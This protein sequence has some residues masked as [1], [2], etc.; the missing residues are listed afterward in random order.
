MSPLK[1][2]RY[3]LAT[4][5]LAGGILLCLPAPKAT[6]TVLW[7]ASPS[8]GSANFQTIDTQTTVKFSVVSDPLGINGQVFSYHIYDIGTGKQRCESKGTVTPTGTLT[9]A[10][11]HNYYVGWKAMWNP[12]PI[13]PGWVALWQLHGY[14]PSG[15]PAPLV[16]RCI[17]NDGNI[18]M[19]NGVNGGNQDF[20]HVPLRLNVWQSFVVHFNISSS[21][22]TGYCEI[23]YNGV[24]QTLAGGVKRLLCQTLD[25]TSGSYD[26][27]KWGVY[28][29]GAMD[30]KG[31]ATAYM[32]GGKVATTLTDA[33]P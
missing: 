9:L 20:W 8:R 3:P 14:G 2:V 30:G 29:S 22:S 25:P 7:A 6:A 21:A 16:L 26:A 12:M 24:Q 32:S 4:A 19:Q 28:R 13:N 11:N 1:S 18:S 27:L 31:P 5:L 10:N 17:N 33:T 15:Q 23:W